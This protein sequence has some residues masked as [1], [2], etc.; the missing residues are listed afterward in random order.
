MTIKEAREHASVKKEQIEIQARINRLKAQLGQIE[1]DGVVLDTVK[2]T[3]K[4]GSLGTIKVRGVQSN[5]YYE[6]KKELS[7]RISRANHLKEILE[8][9]TEAFEQYVYSIDNSRVRRM[10]AMRYIDGLAWQQ[11]ADKMGMDYS[12]DSCRITVKRHFEGE[13]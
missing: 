5:K 6:K 8:I 9:N 2:G 10:I 7:R 3:R 1:E 13:K 4:D 11:I 12:A